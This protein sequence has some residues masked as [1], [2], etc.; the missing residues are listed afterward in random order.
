MDSATASGCPN[1]V[2]VAFSLSWILA[3]LGDARQHHCG[4]QTAAMNSP[5]AGPMPAKCSSG[6]LV[7][8]RCPTRGRFSSDKGFVFFVNLGKGW[9]RNQRFT[10]TSEGAQQSLALDLRV[11][12]RHDPPE[13]VAMASQRSKN[14]ARLSS[15]RN[16]AL[17]PTLPAHEVMNRTTPPTDDGRSELGGKIGRRGNN[18]AATGSN[19]TP[20]CFR[21]A[22]P[23]GATT[24]QL[25]PANGREL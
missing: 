3:V 6:V 17:R 13:S 1:E 11:Q 21:R 19:A 23:G 2:M 16:I 10:D 20:N 22:C 4:C 7:T 14:A 18:W 15:S 9:H 8:T 24:D 12:R 5:T 25:R